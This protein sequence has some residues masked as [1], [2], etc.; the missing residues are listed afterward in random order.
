MTQETVPT[1]IRRE[2]IAS[3]VQSQ[4]FVRVDYLSEEFGISEVTVRSDLA[5]LERVGAV[6]RVR[7]GAAPNGVERSFEESLEELSTEKTAIG[8]AAAAMVTDGQT[9]ML[10]VGTTSNAVAQALLRRSDLTDVMVITNGVNIALAL[11]AAIPRFTV[12]VT[13]GTL[14][15][16]QHSLVDPL[17]AAMLDELN[18]DICFVGC[19]GV[20]VESGVTNANI[21]EAAI[22]RKM[23]GGAHKTVVV[24][25]SSKFGHTSSARIAD[26][27][28]VDTIVTDKS[29]D[30][31]VLA[32]VVDRGVKVVTV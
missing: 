18:A 4:P 28:D 6:R 20:D 19:N 5:E 1:E 3:L 2:R 25:D 15:P 32:E 10:D 26:L 22:K 30:P 21:P 13:G 31:F 12:V 24:A 16:L 17:G 8:Q 9:I 23:M 29:V 14:R 27:A 11:E 7:G